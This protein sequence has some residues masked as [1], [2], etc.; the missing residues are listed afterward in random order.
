M[1]GQVVTEV[2][3]PGQNNEGVVEGALLFILLMAE[4]AEM[5]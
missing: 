1:A 5:D 2:E 4:L 3:R